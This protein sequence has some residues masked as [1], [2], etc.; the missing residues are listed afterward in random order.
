MNLAFVTP[1]PPQQTGIADY[2]FQLVKNF[3]LVDGEVTVITDCPNPVPLPGIKIIKPE[4]ALI[5][6]GNFD[7][8]VY[9]L[10]N[11]SNFHIYQIA[12]LKRFP[13]VIHLH[14]MVMHHI[15]AY[16][17]WVKGS[18]ALYR[19]VLAKWYG[20]SLA[21]QFMDVAQTGKYPWDKPEIVE[22][23]FFEEA[24][25]YAQAVVVHSHFAEEKLRKVFTKKKIVVIP[26][27]YDSVILNDGSRR[28][29]YFHV[30][31]FGGVDFNK[32]IDV[33]VDAFQGLINKGI[34]VKLHI[35]GKISPEVAIPMERLKAEALAPFV[36]T[37]GRIEESVFL[38]MIAEMDFILSLRYPTMGE[39]SAIVMRALQAR[40]PL[41][42]ND[43]GWYSEL[44]A[45]IP[46][47]KPGTEDE[48]EQLEKI[49]ESL[50][51]KSDNYIK[52]KKQ[53]NDWAD[54]ELN[55][56]KMLEKYSEIIHD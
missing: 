10:G 56:S 42:V 29:D 47:L 9:Q 32:R 5:E 14:D 20:S 23:P 24:L 34:K 50:C 40:V 48:A 31:I 46:K 1:W 25:Q 8:F 37:Y 15:M 35:A 27:L 39:V 54:Q 49:I 52:L 2:A 51:D 41:L 13:G 55:Y 7:K 17:L 22:T 36:K 4:V 33:I 38:K 21:K 53:L 26:Q 6:A 45:F 12:L 44:P 11:N 30:G 3:N 28:D 19:V 18:P 43:V 16:I